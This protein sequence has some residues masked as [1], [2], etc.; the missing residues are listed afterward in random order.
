MIDDLPP[1]VKHQ[2]N[3]CSLGLVVHHPAYETLLEYATG[4]FSINSGRNCTKEEIHAAVMRGPHESALEDKYI[5][6]FDYEAKGNVESKLA[7]L[8]LYYEVRGDLPEQMKVS[9]IATIPHNS[10]TFRSIL[11]LSFLLHLIPH[12]LV[13][14]VNDNSRKTSL[15][16]AMDQIGHVLMC[17]IYTFAEAQE[18]AKTFQGKWDIKDGF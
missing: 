2:N 12:E 11:D 5:G 6:H 15:G 4:G 3:L 7:R 14:S 10:K 17:L 16:V 1:P 18:C 13:P 9:P 8:V